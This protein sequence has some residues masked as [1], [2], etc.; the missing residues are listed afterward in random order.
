[1]MVSKKKF[2]EIGGFDTNLRVTYNDVDLCLKL[3]DKGY[4]NLYTPYTR[5][6][7]YE[8]KSVGNIT[9]EKRDKSE[10]QEAF[11]IMQRRWD[12]YLQRDPYYNDNFVQ[13]GP[14]Y[15]LE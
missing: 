11:D 5:L 8:S 14:G 2:N 12:K 9:T 4:L 1:M 6:V 13:H 7:H 10:W 3:L 15:N